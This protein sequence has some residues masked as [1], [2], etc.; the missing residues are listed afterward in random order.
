MNRF[1]PILILTSTI[2]TLV[3]GCSVTIGTRGGYPHPRPANDD[4]TLSEIDAVS[5][6]SF[7][8]GKLSAYQD[9]ASS[10]HLSADAQMYLVER[11]LDE[12]SFESSKQSV[13]MT[14]INNP[15]FLAEGK[16]AIIDNLD[17]FSFESSKQS[18]LRALS[19]RGPVPSGLAE[20]PVETET[21]VEVEVGYGETL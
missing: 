18:I 5:R 10:P 20:V 15:C 8:S 9:I 6:L 17:A 11:S 21:T 12:M 3:C 7:E 19:K 1:I 4:V 16:G 13:V 2:T 14:L